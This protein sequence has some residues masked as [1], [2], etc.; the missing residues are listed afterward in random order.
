MMPMMRPNSPSLVGRVHAVESH[1]AGWHRGQGEQF[2][3]THVPEIQR[4]DPI[5][6]RP[7]IGQMISGLHSGS[8][9][10]AGEEEKSGKPQHAMNEGRDAF[11]EANA[12][13]HPSPMDIVADVAV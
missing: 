5:G 12:P 8:G 2:L 1:E 11:V 10:V 7:H 6:V 13:L 9:Y 3:P 4:D